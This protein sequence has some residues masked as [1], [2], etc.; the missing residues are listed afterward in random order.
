MFV[1]EKT[2]LLLL[3]GSAN[4]YLSGPTLQVISQAEPGASH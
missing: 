4:A 2:K 1:K 3:G